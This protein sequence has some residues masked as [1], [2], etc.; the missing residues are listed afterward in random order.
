MKHVGIIAQNDHD[1]GFGHI[2]RAETLYKYLKKKRKVYFFYL[3]RKFNCFT[4]NKKKVSKTYFFKK[5]LTCSSVIIDD[6]NLSLF[7]GKKIKKKNIKIVSLSPISKINKIADIIYGRCKPI[8]KSNS[9]CLIFSDMKYFIA[10]NE[11]RHKIK[12]N[13][14][15]KN[16]SKIIKIGIQMSAYDKNNL[17]LN[18]IK[19]FLPYKNFFFFNISISGVLKENKLQLISY[20][21]K[22]NFNYNILKFKNNWRY[23]KKCNL[24]FLG[25]GLSAYEA[26]ILGIPSINIIDK[27][28]KFSLIEDLQK[29]KL[30]KIFFIKNI[31]EA[32]FEIANMSKK[33][34]IQIAKKLNTFNNFKST[35][36]SCNYLI[37]NIL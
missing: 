23:F 5:I 28:W 22:Y 13:F 33:R 3:S 27:K 37:K 29:K 36:Y 17:T 8:S 35:K 30:T 10:G 32:V 14:Y 6:L 26:S 21:K 7:L 24:L 34:L 9:E 1:V 16:F 15:K 18:I 25:G 12:L 4:K 2:K 11:I 19:N 20:L 31:A